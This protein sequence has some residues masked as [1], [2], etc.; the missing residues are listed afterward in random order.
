MKMVPNGPL[1]LSP[2]L[3]LIISGSKAQ[4]RT[5]S[6]TLWTCSKL[7]SRK[8]NNLSEL[9]ASTRGN[10][11]PDMFPTGRWAMGQGIPRKNLAH[12]WEMA[13]CFEKSETGKDLLWPYPPTADCS[14]LLN[15][16]RRKPMWGSE[17]SWEECPA[18]TQNSPET[19][20]K[21]AQR[22]YLRRCL[23]ISFHYQKAGLTQT[24]FSN[25]PRSYEAGAALTNIV[26]CHSPAN[27]FEQR[28][29]HQLAELE[30]MGPLVP[31][32]PSKG[33]KLRINDV[34]IRRN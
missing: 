29:P 22:V 34:L 21:E 1:W 15:L 5:T 7:N 20:L 9:S 24:L 23:R 28:P 12:L 26:T 16:D 11:Y 32:G 30:Q 3:M 10:R 33:K 18:E 31:W 8:G 25:C 14:L 17:G 6:V 27:M 19:S 2:L 13:I 4:E